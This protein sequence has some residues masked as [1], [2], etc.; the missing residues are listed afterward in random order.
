MGDTDEVTARTQAEL[1][2]G[3]DEIRRSPADEGT[4]R[5]IV[6]RPMTD[7]R[8][9]VE[10]AQLDTAE[11]LVGDVW[12]S[13][14][15]RSMP[16]GGPD[17][18]AQVTL[19]NA[20]VLTLLGLPQEFAT[21]RPHKNEILEYQRSIGEF[22]SDEVYAQVASDIEERRHAI[23]ERERPNGTVL[24]AAMYNQLLLDSLDPA[25]ARVSGV[26]SSFVDYLFVMLLLALGVLSA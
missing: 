15:S 24:T 12:R 7:E 5:L 26:W 19:M 6:R 25:V 13:R 17:P 2:A 20:R 18:D 16:D 22:Q 21:R 10:S 1:E 23:Y 11:G 9:V 14:G 3:L 4:V 8:E